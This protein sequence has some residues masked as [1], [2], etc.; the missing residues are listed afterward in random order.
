MGC[1]LF[2]LAVGRKAFRSDFET[3]RFTKGNAQLEIPLDDYF[4]DDCKR[5]IR[6][7]VN[8]ML[9]IDGTRRPNV[10]QL[11][12]NFGEKVEKYERTSHGGRGKVRYSFSQVPTYQSD[13]ALFPASVPS[14]GGSSSR[15]LQPGS[16]RR[17]KRNLMIHTE[18]AGAPPSSPAP[19]AVPTL[20]SAHPSQQPNPAQMNSPSISQGP[21]SISVRSGQTHR[22]L[23]L[24][25]E[26]N[27]RPQHVQ[28]PTSLPS[29][30]PSAVS[31]KPYQSRNSVFE[32]APPFSPMLPSPCATSSSPAVHPGRDAPPRTVSRSLNQQSRGGGRANDTPIK[33]PSPLSH[34]FLEALG[35]AKVSN[36]SKTAIRKNPSSYLT[37]Q[38][39]CEE[40]E[41]E[42][43]PLD[44]LQVF[45]SLA[46]LCPSIPAPL[47]QL[48]NLHAATGD[49]KSAIEIGWKLQ[50]FSIE[51][52]VVALS[53]RNVGTS[54]LR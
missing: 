8:S 18:P 26:L 44:G 53:P 5:D 15:Q 52:L 34:L 1:I 6:K 9:R 31:G 14:P 38:H 7:Y 2:E 39:L 12:Q 24:E 16:L 50:S 42:A 45:A 29:P 10:T 17:P 40:P 23:I 32:I 33:T 3:K 54:T 36:R 22:R 46:Q 41:S 21:P 13:H 49:Y 25:K 27:E 4:G 28:K 43:N 47:I 20:R 48:T 37:W 11:V 51:A 35:A 19:L 30:Q